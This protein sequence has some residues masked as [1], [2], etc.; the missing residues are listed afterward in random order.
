MHILSDKEHLAKE[1]TTVGYI[2]RDEI[3]RKRRRLRKWNICN[4]N[5]KDKELLINEAYI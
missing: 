1:D 3:S 5:L 4:G 2:I